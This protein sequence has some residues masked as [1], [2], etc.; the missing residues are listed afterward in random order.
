MPAPPTQVGARPDPSGERLGQ[1]PEASGRERVKREVKRRA[2]VVGFFP[3]D[4]A[5][6]RPVGA[7]LRETN[8]EGAVARRYRSLETL[9]RITNIPIV[10]LPAVA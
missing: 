4:D 8:D 1:E 6:I 3:D 2:D 10:R 5:I 9:A 7:L